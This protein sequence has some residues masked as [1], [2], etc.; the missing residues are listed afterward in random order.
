MDKKEIL[1]R[2]MLKVAENHQKILKKLAQDSGYQGSSDVGMELWTLVGMDLSKFGCTISRAMLRG[3]GSLDV[4]VKSKA[5][6]SLDPR[7]MNRVKNLI[8]GALSSE[9]LAGR[10]VDTSKVKVNFV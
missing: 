9:E 10:T 7:V 4:T 1:I 8:S 2:K 6:A 5:G 3:D